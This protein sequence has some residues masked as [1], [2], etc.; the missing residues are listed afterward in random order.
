MTN[1]VIG[2]GPVGQIMALTLSL[3]NRK[4]YLIGPKQK[5]LHNMAFSIHPKYLRFLHSL[6]VKPDHYPVHHMTLDFDKPATFTSKAPITYIIRYTS[7]LKALETKLHNVHQIQTLCTRLTLNTLELPQQSILFE[8]L[9]ACDG[10]HSWTRDQLHIP[11]KQF[12]YNQY[13]HTAIITHTQAQEGMSQV[14]RDYGT[15]ARLTLPNTHQSAIV[16][17]CDTP[18]HQKIQTEGLV[19]M[20]DSQ[21]LLS[22][23]LL[24][25][26]HEHVPLKATLSSAYYKNRIFFAGNALH[27]VH[28]LAGIGLN[29]ALGD[30]QAI[31]AVLC[32]NQPASFYPQTR[33]KVHQ[34]A[35][36]LTHQIAKS[37][38]HPKYYPWVS[39]LHEYGSKLNSTSH[40]LLRQ[41]HAI[42]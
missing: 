14:F 15:F 23:V 8:N 34:K 42:C 26:H 16:W 12:P 18:T 36:W 24:V 7:L 25:E 28:P 19:A 27:T 29:L 32:E 6:G 3:C 22:D 11:S 5:P 13:A 30:I 2:S 20:L 17:C 9:I 40:F 21:K 10:Q 38:R 1:V 39:R 4:V 31:H 41:L 35:H 33:K 37:R